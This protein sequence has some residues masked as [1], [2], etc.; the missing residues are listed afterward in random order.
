MKNPYEVLGV[1]PTASD[2]EI[3]AAYRRLA[4]KYHPDTNS[5]SEYAAEKMSEINA[6]YDKIC[7]MRSG[8]SSGY[9]EYTDYTGNTDGGLSYAQ[10]LAGARSLIAADN[11]PAAHNVLLSFP[12][13]A[14]NA[15]WYYL[16]GHVNL[17]LGNK[18]MAAQNFA[19]AH[20]FEPGNE[21]YK[22][23]FDAVNQRSSTYGEYSRNENID[24]CNY[25]C[26]CCDFCTCLCCL[27]NCLGCICNS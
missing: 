12:A 27:D 4:K 9:S 26:S 24:S 7:E 19:Y 5:G 14:R 2:E 10:M 1:S 25:G 17:R 3:K 8:K 15:E 20:S 18:S 23:A 13:S 22:R 11:I 16:M 6:A 21:E